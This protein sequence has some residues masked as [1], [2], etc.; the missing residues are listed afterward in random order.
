MSKI[1]KAAKAKVENQTQGWPV[2][3]YFALFGG[4]FL[5]YLAGRIVLAS[6]PHPWHWL[7]AVVGGVAGCLAGWVWYRARGDII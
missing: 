1:A 6:S 7:S 2:V 4:A 3:V 5:G